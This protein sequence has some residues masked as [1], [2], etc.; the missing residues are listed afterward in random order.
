VTLMDKLTRKREK[1]LAK[2]EH[3]TQESIIKEKVISND[4]KSENSVKK[5]TCS[6]SKC[7]KLYC[8][9]FA[10]GQPCGPDCGCKECC[11]NEGCTDLI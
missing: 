2:V 10:S 8:E 6:K 7:L 9:C 3:S 4:E 5:C 11:N 1:D